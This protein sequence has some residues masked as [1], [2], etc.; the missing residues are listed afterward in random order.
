MTVKAEPIR[1]VDGRQLPL[2]GTWQ[3]DPVHSEVQFAVQHMMIAKVRGRFREFTCTIQIASNPVD[4]SVETVINAASIDTGDPDRDEHLR[5]ADFLDVEHHPD[6]VFRSTSVHPS[7][8]DHWEV[9]GDLTV[10]H[11]SVPTVLDIEYLGSTIDPWGSTRSAFQASTEVDRQD[12][13][14][15]WNK[16]LEAGGFLVGRRVR[17]ELDIEAVLVDES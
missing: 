15:S 12:F 17:I 6:I 8:E 3:A 7:D 10:L 9:V 1:V 5:S 13:G 4:S 16:A 11:A 14:I 2:P